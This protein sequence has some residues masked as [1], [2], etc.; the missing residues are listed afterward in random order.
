MNVIAFALALANSGFS[1]E[2]IDGLISI[3]LEIVEFQKKIRNKNNKTKRIQM[4]SALDLENDLKW[5]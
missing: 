3:T 1:G 2:S 4:M 5:I